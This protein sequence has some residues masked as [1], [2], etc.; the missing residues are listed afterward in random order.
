MCGEY[1]LLSI[2]RQFPKQPLHAICPIDQI[3]VTDTHQRAFVRPP[4]AALHA[5]EAI[6]GTFDFFEGLLKGSEDIEK[7][8]LEHGAIGEVRN[9]V[10]V[11]HVGI[12]FFL[13]IFPCELAERFGAKVDAV[14]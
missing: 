5:D 12:E 9:I 11:G 1:G 10:H 4:F 14:D 3:Q 8:R 7:A 6:I 13:H 2:S